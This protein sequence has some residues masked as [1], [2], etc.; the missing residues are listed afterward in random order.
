MSYD[1][2]PSEA[3]FV[4]L[5]LGRDSA[6]FA[7]HCARADVI[8]RPFPGE[9]VRVTIGLAEENERFL[10]AATDWTAQR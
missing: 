4:W 7:E 6:G 8:V 3:N 2:T 9:G 10:T 1:V 5:P